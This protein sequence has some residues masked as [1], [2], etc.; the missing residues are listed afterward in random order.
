MS[1]KSTRANKE[2]PK[3]DNIVNFYNHPIVQRL[4]PK[5]DDD[6]FKRTGIKNN[7]KTIVIGSTESG[8][9]SFVLNY[10]SR[11]TYRYGHISIVNSGMVEPLYKF[12]ENR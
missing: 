4:N 3:P 1:K 11:C 7:L 12:L 6:C 10:L 9:S 5:F 2:G 8:K